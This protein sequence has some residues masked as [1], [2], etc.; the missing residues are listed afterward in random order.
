MPFFD[1]KDAGIIKIDH[2]DKGAPICPSTCHGCFHIR[3][4]FRCQLTGNR[5]AINVNIVSRVQKDARI[6]RPDRL[7]WIPFIHIR[8]WTNEDIAQIAVR[9]FDRTRINLDVSHLSLVRPTDEQSF[10]SMETIVRIDGIDDLTCRYVHF[11][12]QLYLSHAFTPPDYQMAGF[13]LAPII[14]SFHSGHQ[15]FPSRCYQ[16]C[17]QQKRSLQETR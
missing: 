3:I 11:R 14:A 6:L 10:Y 1:T 17:E 2:L 13:S 9:I 15:G 4:P 7:L 5:L 12:R 16:N 8:F